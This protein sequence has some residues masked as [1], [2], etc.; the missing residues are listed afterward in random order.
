MSE[1]QYYEFQAL[2][3]PLSA[4][5]QAEMK[6]LSSRVQLTATSASFVYNYGDFRGS[7][8]KVLE[9]YFDMMLYMT[10]WGTRQLM[11][12][13]PKDAI[14][15]AVKKAYQFEYY[16]TWTSS[17]NYVVLNIL[18]DFEEG[19]GWVNGEGILPGIVTLRN[20][21]LMGDY[22]ALYL[23]WLQIVYLEYVI[24]E[25]KGEENLLEPPVPPNLKDLSTPLRNLIDFFELDQKLIQIGASPSIFGE[26]LQ[27]DLKD[28]ITQLSETEKNEFLERLLNNESHLTIALTN[29]LRELAGTKKVAFPS[30]TSK[31]RTV[32]E[33][34]EQL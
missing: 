26:S 7:P 28:Y 20:D 24:L 34:I 6:E 30:D 21:I 4:K 16:M 2:D 10:N 17:P 22:R 29:R 11:F 13:F 3:E 25:D 9:K 8:E 31:R 15:D 14:P 23:A 19:S 32:Q 27:G 5:A 33:I 1:Y 12:R 18:V